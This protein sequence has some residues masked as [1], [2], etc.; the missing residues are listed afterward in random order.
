[1]LAAGAGVRFAGGDHK[2]RTAVRGKAILTWAV[3]SALAARLDA[4]IVV[5]G[6]VDV[7]DLVP[8]GAI[9]VTNDRW[10]EGQ[11]TSLQCAIGWAGE[12]GFDAVVVGLGDQPF[13]TP[14]AWRAVAAADAPIAVATYGGQRRNPV[15]LHRDVWPLLPT[16]GDEGARRVVAGNAELV[17]E[18]ACDGDPGDVD[19]VEDLEAWN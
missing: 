4:T 6:A 10:A 12:H 5:A 15:K 17:R 18:V 3:E 13:V 16:S 9:V 14:G 7:A 19:T 8:S 11:A 2:L 1:M